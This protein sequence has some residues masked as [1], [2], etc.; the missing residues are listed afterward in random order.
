MSLQNVVEYLVS[1]QSC[2]APA[3][4]EKSHAR[5]LLG[6]RPGLDH[7]TIS[8][9]YGLGSA[10]SPILAHALLHFR[11]NGPRQVPSD[12][13]TSKRAVSDLPC[14]LSASAES[15]MPS[16]HSVLLID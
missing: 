10:T 15:L 8:A 5:N 16:M 7:L 9:H 13:H 6:A 3:E 11:L 12:M 4:H 2:S 14:S 1:P